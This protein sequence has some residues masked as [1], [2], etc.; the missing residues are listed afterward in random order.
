MVQLEILVKQHHLAFRTGHVLTLLFSCFAHHTS[1]SER[2]RESFLSQHHCHGGH[3]ARLTPNDLQT[4]WRQVWPK[5]PTWLS[6][7][8]L[9]K[10]SENLRLRRRG[11]WQV[12]PH[13]CTGERCLRDQ[14]DPIRPSANHDT[15]KYWNA[16]KRHDNHRRY[17]SLA[18]RTKHPAQR[19]SKIQC[20]TPRVL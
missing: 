18:P 10:S 13:H 15:S 2:F 16:G 11:Y 6:D 14:Q 20:H 1:L 3:S 9:Q 19:A 5:I 17:I 4:V 12:Q 7:V 8:G